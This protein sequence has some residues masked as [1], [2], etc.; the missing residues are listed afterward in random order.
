MPERVDHLHGRIT[1]RRAGLHD[2]L[3]DAPGEIV[4]EEV[5]ALLEHIAVVLPADQIGQPR[6]DGL[7]GEQVVQAEHQGPD[8]HSHHGHP[9]QLIAVFGEKTPRI[10]RG[11]RHVDQL[12]KKAEQRHFDQRRK[13]AHHQHSSHQRPDLLQIMRVEAQH[14]RRR[15]DVRAGLEDID[16]VFET[17]EQHGA[18]SAVASGRGCC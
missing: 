17:A 6:V 1:Q 13:E 10:A 14:A 3:G 15:L 8:D 9:Q 11:L 16:Q 4:L 12:A 7:V 18:R 2:A 5:Q